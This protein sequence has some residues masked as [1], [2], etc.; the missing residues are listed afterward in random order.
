MTAQDNAVLPARQM[1][2]IKVDNLLINFTT[3]FQRIQ[4]TAGLRSQSASFWRPMPDPD[5][6]PGYFPLGDI[7][8]HNRN[9]PNGLLITAVVREGES[10]GEGKSKTNALTRPTDFEQIWR[11]TGSGS[12][13]R[14]AMW[15]PIPPEG[16]VAL[17]T[18]C[19]SDHDKPSLN[20][21]RCVREDLVV[22]A[23]IGNQ[24]W[25]DKSSGAKNNFSA[26]SVTPRTAAEG[27]IHFAPG[28]FIGVKSYIEPARHY[29]AYALRIP[30]AVE[31]SSP[32]E[33][34]M[35]T[36]NLSPLSAGAE[37]VTH[38]VRLPWFAVREQ[39]PPIEQFQ[40]SP[41][42]ELRRTDQYMLVGS[43]RNDTD[44]AQSVKWLARPDHDRD[45]ILSYSGESALKIAKHWP[46]QV[47]SDIR[48][49]RFSALLPKSFSHTE[50]TST[51]WGNPHPVVV[52]AMAAKGKSV[53]VYRMH[54]LY[55]LLRADGTKMAFDTH[56]ADN[57]SLYMTEFP[58]QLE[59]VAQ[60]CPLPL[61]TSSTQAP[62][63]N[64]DMTSSAQAATVNV[65]MTVEPAPELPVVPVVTDSAP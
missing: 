37:K 21:V 1:E 45:E 27:E 23:N 24:I 14:L 2:S 62:T 22:G 31:V 58:A 49:T 46:A 57:S 54:S 10:P 36:T 15:R 39:L 12:V 9:N 48:M 3:E 56:Y 33:A 25:N 7:A 65:D 32:A 60:H 11:D 18:V 26:W 34:P 8:L 38:V 63:I 61:K 4:D 42:Y 50:T 43:A 17:G 16:Y 55:E 30:I 5:L 13:M 44:Q 29:A 41:I 51:E 59:E 6:L 28:T 40:Q 52:I 47:L 20:S 53:A 19:T 64:V 35:L